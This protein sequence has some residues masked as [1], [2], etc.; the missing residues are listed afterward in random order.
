MIVTQPLPALPVCGEQAGTPT[1]PV[2]T[3][4]QVTPTPEPLGPLGV[5]EATSV[6]P[7]LRVLQY[8]AV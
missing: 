4:L 5:Q 3:V 6:V 2:A 1:G 8:V 7:R